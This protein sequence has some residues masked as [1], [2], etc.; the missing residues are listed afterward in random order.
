M[1]HYLIAIGE[2]SNPI[3]KTQSKQYVIKMFSILDLLKPLYSFSPSSNVPLGATLTAFNVTSDGTQI[4]V[5]FSSGT[6]SVFL[7]NFLKQSFASADISNIDNGKSVLDIPIP[8]IFIPSQSYPVSK[9]LFADIPSDTPLETTSDRELDLEKRIVLYIVINKNAETAFTVPVSKGNASNFGITSELAPS[10]PAANSAGIFAVDV[11]L[12]VDAVSDL[13]SLSSTRKPAQYLDEEGATA[14]CVSYM[15][16]TRELIVGR[17]PG[18][19]SYSPDDRG[20]AVGL[21]GNKT[22]VQ[23]IRNYVLIASDMA[24]GGASV[25]SGD[26]GTSIAS[27][28]ASA[29]SRELVTIYDLRNKLVVGATHL[30]SSILNVN[31]LSDCNLLTLT[32]TLTAQLIEG[33]K[34]LYQV[35][36]NG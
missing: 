32:L 12:R 4:A 29:L 1:R 18:I 23:C 2:D 28:S 5:G 20:G 16:D 13:V 27:G 17:E 35:H 26:D 30:V 34:R 14:A 9:L 6:V 10:K 22:C 15:A 31:L 3:N 19:F 33:T 21:E 24:H 25:T 36:S 7:N 11:S 8:Q